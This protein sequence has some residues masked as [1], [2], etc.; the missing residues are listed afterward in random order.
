M[1]SINKQKEPVFLAEYKR[2]EPIEYEEIPKDSI[3]ESLLKEQG[4]ICAYCMQRIDENKMK[5][6]HWHSQEKHEDERLDYK[7]MLAVCKGNEG[8]SPKQQHCD[9]KKADK[10]I[11]YNPANPEHKIESKI[12]YKTS[13]G[14]IFSEDTEF[15]EQLN[16]V[17]NLNYRIL[18]ENR[19]AVFDAVTSRLGYLCKK[20][21]VT[22]Q[23]LEKL[24]EKWKSFENGHRK[25]YSG[26]AVYYLN[27][28]ILCFG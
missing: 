7:N 11:K 22:K 16:K 20:E 25:E 9:T 8:H 24:I 10:D 5:I 4:F 21:G 19:K 27:K 2:R 12:K 1:V 3:R 23:Q 28:K 18:K 14:E 26:V 6:E 13:N 15:N 17:L